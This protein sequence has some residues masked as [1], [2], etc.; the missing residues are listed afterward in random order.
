MPLDKGLARRQVH[1]A[2][3][4]CLDRQFPHGEGRA[5]S[6]GSVLVERD[7][8]DAAPPARGGRDADGALEALWARL[9]GRSSGGPGCTTSSGARIGCPPPPL[10]RTAPAAL[11]RCPAPPPPAQ[12]CFHQ[13][14]QLHGRPVA[15]PVMLLGARWLVGSN[16]SSGAAL[17]VLPLAMEADGFLL[18][19]VMSLIVPGES[20]TPAGKLRQML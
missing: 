9:D 16:P 8:G 3:V 19:Q 17:A 7:P 20:G 18:A 14:P 4:V 13:L 12:H 11:H 2:T 15:H 6:R 10:P 5:G 1:V